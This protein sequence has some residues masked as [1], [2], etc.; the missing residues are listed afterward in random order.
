MLS[1]ADLNLAE[2]D[3]SVRRLQVVCFVHNIASESEEQRY[4]TTCKTMRE[5]DARF[6]KRDYRV[7][8][9]RVD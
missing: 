6:I 1:H 8:Q 2:I 4:N 9:L 5:Y 7:L 3:Q